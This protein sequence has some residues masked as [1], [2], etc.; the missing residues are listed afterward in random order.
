MGPGLRKEVRLISELHQ[1]TDIDYSLIREIETTTASL[2][3][4]PV[5]LELSQIEDLGYESG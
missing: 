5:P 3:D 2:H 1:K 4:A